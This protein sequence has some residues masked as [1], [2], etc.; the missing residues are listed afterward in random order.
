MLYGQKC[1]E[2]LLLFLT[3]WQYVISMVHLKTETNYLKKWICWQNAKLIPIVFGCK[4]SSSSLFTKCKIF[5]SPFAF[6]FE[7]E[8]CYTYCFAALLKLLEKTKT[9]CF[10]D[11]I[12]NF[13]QCWNFFAKSLP[14]ISTSLKPE[15]IQ[16][17]ISC[18]H[19]L[20]HSF[21]NLVL[22]DS[23]TQLEVRL[24]NFR[25]GLLVCYLF[26]E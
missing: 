14:I 12:Q 15:N 9:F 16:L 20:H 21:Q 17:C 6:A 4:R 13:Y 18:V 22:F 19:S 8:Y 1:S 26:R 11:S 7:N 10:F 2:S 25:Y 5:F 23:T 24:S 3:N